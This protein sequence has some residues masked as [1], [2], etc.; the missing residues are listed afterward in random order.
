MVSIWIRLIELAV[1]AVEF[2]QARI[3]LTFRG[4]LAGK[5]MNVLKVRLNSPEISVT[6]AEAYP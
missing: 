5:A 6:A 1:T 4:K 3:A 2:G